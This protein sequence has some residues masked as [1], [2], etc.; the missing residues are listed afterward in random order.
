MVLNAASLAVE[1]DERECYDDRFFIE[2][3]FYPFIMFE[4]CEPRMDDL[5]TME[6][7]S[8]L[9]SLSWNPKPEADVWQRTAPPSHPQGS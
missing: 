8:R 6:E 5:I 9:V 7:L 3:G 1:C 2:I 4:P